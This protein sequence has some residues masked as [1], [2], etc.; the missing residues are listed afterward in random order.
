MMDRNRYARVVVGIPVD[1]IFD[2]LIPEPLLERLKVGMRV[3]VPFGKRR[4]LGYVI[5]IADKAEVTDIKEVREVLD[6]EPILPENLLKLTRWMAN[7]YFYSWGMAIKT[8][9]PSR[10]NSPV[11]KA[12]KRKVSETDKYERL[13]LPERSD[14]ALNKFQFD[15]LKRIKEGLK[16]GGFNTFLLHGI[17]GSGKT[18]VYMQAIA[19]LGEK[20]AIV[21]VPEISLTSRFVMRFRKRFGRRVA[22]FHSGLSEKE[23]F[24][25]WRRIHKGESE[26]VIGVRSA[27]FAPFRKVSLI[28]IDEEQ[29][30]SYKQE[31]GLR[32][33]ARDVAIMRG[34]IEGANVILG[35]ST[36]SVESFY[37]ARK[38]R[39]H[40]LSLPERI[41]RRPF[42]AIS[43]ID[44]SKEKKKI[45]SDRLREGISDRLE[46]GEKVLLLINRR[47]YS[48]FILCRECGYSPG[49]P[50]CSITLTYHKVTNKESVNPVLKCHY[51][52]YK[53]APPTI[54][55]DCGGINIGYIG[56]GTERAE[57]E[58]T[59]SYPEASILRIDRDTTRRKTTFYRVSRETFQEEG[60]TNQDTDIILGTQIIAKGNDFP[61]VTLAGA[62]WADGGLHIPDFRSGERTFQ[63]MTQLAEKVGT[64]EIP[65]ELIIQTHNPD[66]YSLR[67][68]KANDYYGFYKEEIRLRKEL[69]YPPFYRIIRI[70]IKC[71]NEEGL[72][73]KI[74]ELKGI[75]KASDTKDIEILG[76]A[77]AHI[78]KLKGM[79]RWHLILKGKSHVSLHNYASRL[80]ETIKERKFP[81]IRID[82]DVDPIR[83]V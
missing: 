26:I 60:I 41:D 66:H 45:I 14:I 23:R 29:D 52:N 36:P 13:H 79:Y 83:M 64:G 9:L 25:E 3:L 27:V 49:C 81:G 19:N 1:N 82:I 2:Y 35:S 8:S 10:L 63:L 75:I 47:G 37:N 78:Y 21:L 34:K 74:P 7:Y 6:D 39:Y 44:I 70:I 33:N 16:N 4:L 50:D 20:G 38:G 77:P 72:V 42:P 32:F 51:C 40:Y 30:P 67:Y 73:K 31:E 71:D 68:I 61:S 22:V 59:K 12:R 11:H 56:V 69:R 55:P 17:A 43:L 48:P 24:D 80:N 18:E 62:V 57:E 15:A 65:G 76:P 54:C 5:G 58:I 46:R 28:I 53:T